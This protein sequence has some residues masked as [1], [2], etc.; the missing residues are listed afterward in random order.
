[1]ECNKSAIVTTIEEAK[2]KVKSV[3]DAIKGFFSSISLKRPHIKLPH[4]S[5]NS[6][7]S[8]APLSVLH[9]SIDWYKKAMNKPML[10]N[11][12]TI[13][14]SKGGNL[15]GGGEAGHE[16]IM[17]LDTLS[18][19][20]AGANGELLSVMTRVLDIMDRYFP[21][22]AQTSIVFDS[23]ELVGGISPK[24]DMELYKLQNRKARGVA[25]VYGMKIGEFH[26]Y[27]DF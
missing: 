3:V 12:A 19:M 17:G 20:T 9:L 26:S 13:F 8:L 6:H 16:V 23:G 7:F 1:M 21:Q 4:F 5:I 22:F 27:K 18:N 15:L 24:I 10:L 2:N 14:G 11:G 25:S